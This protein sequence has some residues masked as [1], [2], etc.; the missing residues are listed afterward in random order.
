MKEELKFDQALTK[1]PIPEFPIWL[2]TVLGR[3]I[4]PMVSLVRRLLRSH[5]R[6]HR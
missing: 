5:Q 4:L 3:H 6:T 2:A 1:D